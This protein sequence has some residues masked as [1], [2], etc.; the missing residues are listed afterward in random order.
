MPRRSAAATTALALLASLFV[1]FAGAP[2]HAFDKDCADF[3][4]QED[5]QV[6][7]LDKGGPTY[8]PD[9]LDADGDGVACESNP[10]PCYYGTQTAGDTGGTTGGAKKVLRQRARI[11]KVI[12]GDTVRVRLI[13]GP[14]RVVR[15]LGIDT[16]EVYGTTV[17]CGGP[18]ASRSLSRMSPKGTRVR[19]VSDPT[20]AYKDRYGRL[21][22]YVVKVSTGRDLSRA[23]VFR[24]WSKVY[25][26]DKPFRRIEGYRVA[27]GQARDAGRGIWGLC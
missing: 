22:R 19:L 13:G 2:A 21:L 17:E 26:Y 5:A 11:V 25:V 24:G 9:A 27:Q 15:M 6:Y 23:Q 18:Q 10:C 14:L 8:D 1:W 16:P 12:D 3:A 20:Q 4:T 7:F